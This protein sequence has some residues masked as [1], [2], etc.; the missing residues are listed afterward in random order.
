MKTRSLTLSDI[1]GT[2]PVGRI[3]LGRLNIKPIFAALFFIAAGILYGY[4]LPALLGFPWEADGINIL[5]HILVFPTAGFFY[6]YQPHSILRTYNSA[7]R[8]LREEEQTHTIHFDKI[9]RTH[10]ARVLWIVGLLFGLLGAGFGVSFSIQHFGEFSYSANW[11]QIIFVQAVRFLAYYCIGVSAGRHIA[12]SIELNGL[13]EHADFPLTVDA[14]RLEVFRSI[15][16]FSLEFVGIAAIIALNLGLA[17]LLTDPPVIEYSLYVSLYFIIAPVSFFLPIWEAHVRMS[18]IKNGV[19]DRLNYDF[20]EE[21]QR[22]Y[23]TLDKHG[24]INSYIDKAE[25]LT[26]LEKAIETVSRTTDWPFQGTTFYRLLVTVLS[27][28]LL[29]IFE[30]FINIVSNFFVPN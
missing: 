18:K 2:D 3:V 11:F 21:S 17:P 10:A 19:L 13:F 6:A 30:I 8:F 28:F 24:R 12:A 29:V 4:L 16:N 1:H 20:Q 26:Q 5:N 9:A 14:D 27:P 7:M 25:T 23:R 15:K 22:L